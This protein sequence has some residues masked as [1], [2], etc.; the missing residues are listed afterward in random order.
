MPES[1]ICQRSLF[2]ESNRIAVI[3]LT[4]LGLRLRLY[5]KICFIVAKVPNPLPGFV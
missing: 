3:H 4:L 2:H 5:R 1:L